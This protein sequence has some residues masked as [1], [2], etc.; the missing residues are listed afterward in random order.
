M[1][2]SSNNKNTSSNKQKKTSE[3]TNNSSN[4]ASQQ[5]LG[6]ASISYADY[7]ILSATLS[8]AIAEE[9]NDADLDMLIVF[10]GM[11]TSDLALLRTKRGITNALSA[12]DTSEE[13]IIGSEEA[14]EG[15]ESIAS[16]SSTLRGRSRKKSKRIKKVKKK[17]RKS[18]NGD[19]LKR[20]MNKNFEN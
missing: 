10:F 19:S 5:G 16:A 14:S 15:G 4:T 1:A 11:V 6:L 18:S 20:E 2:N 8:F 12:Q 7:V 13:A 3:C 17:K 9:L